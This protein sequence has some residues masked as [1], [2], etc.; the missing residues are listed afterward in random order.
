MCCDSEYAVLFPVQR[1]Y[2][3]VDNITPHVADVNTRP[4]AGGG[5]AGSDLAAPLPLLAFLDSS[6]PMDDIDAKLL[7]PNSALI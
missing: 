3:Y 7:A 1:S 5:G 4:A 6:K 2:L